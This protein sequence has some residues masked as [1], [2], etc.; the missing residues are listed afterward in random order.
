MITQI[1]YIDFVL[2]ELLDQHRLFEASLLDDLDNLKVAYNIANLILVTCTST[3]F[4]TGL[5]EQV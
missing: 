2:Y 4:I 5:L 3:N 1:T